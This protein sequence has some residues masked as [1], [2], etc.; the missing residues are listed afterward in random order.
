M[1]SKWP[2]FVLADMVTKCGVPASS[3]T[4]YFV[5]GRRHGFES[6][7]TNSASE[8]SRKFFD[9]PLFFGGGSNFLSPCP[10][11]LQKWRSCPPA[12]MGAPPMTTAISIT[13]SMARSN[14]PRHTCSRFQLYFRTDF[15][16][17]GCF[18]VTGNIISQCPI[19]YESIKSQ[20]CVR[21][22]HRSTM[23]K[24]KIINTPT[25]PCC[26]PQHEVWRAGTNICIC[27][28]YG[29]HCDGTV[30]HEHAQTWQTYVAAAAASKNELPQVSNCQRSVRRRRKA[31][32]AGLHRKLPRK[33]KQLKQQQQQPLTTGRHSPPSTSIYT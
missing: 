13:G 21:Q 26:T 16:V 9:P 27:S 33:E 5:Q 3:G 4:L 30:S 10:L 1:F 7:G 14:K 23:Q 22:F 11:C 32:A 20:S 12:P 15:I 19:Y 31:K 29:W 6:G 25:K 28:L 18:P 17:I 2:S 24:K 8:A